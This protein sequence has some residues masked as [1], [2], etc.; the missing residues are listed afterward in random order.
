VP[1]TIVKV[2][3]TENDTGYGAIAALPVRARQI[4]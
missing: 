2:R 1:L 3:V 4:A